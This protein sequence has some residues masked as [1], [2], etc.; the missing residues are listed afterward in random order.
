MSSLEEAIAKMKGSPI[1]CV[2][3]NGRPVAM[4]R[5]CPWQAKEWV[6]PWSRLDALSF[7]HE[8]E[9]ERVELFFPHHHVVMVGENLR[10]I[11]DDIPAFEV[12]C[13]RDL[14]ASRRAALEPAEP[15]IF[16]LDVHLLTDPRSRPSDGLPF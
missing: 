7:S 11:R 9:A 12:R 3:T 2:E 6:L 15:F 5:F 1:R 10:K 13:L 8:E 4:V 16:R 14:P